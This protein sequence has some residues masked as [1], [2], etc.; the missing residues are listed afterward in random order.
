MTTLPTQIVQVPPDLP[1]LSYGDEGEFVLVLEQML[2]R[3]GYFS[4]SPDEKFLRLT[5]DAVRLF[6]MA[7]LGPDGEWLK[8][9]SVVG[10]K[11]WWALHNP[12]GPAQRSWIEA[13]VPGGLPDYRQNLLELVCSEHQRGVREIPDG[14]NWGD[15]VTKYLDG[16]G[17]A[18]W[19]NYFVSWAFKEITG[20]YLY[21]YRQGHVLS[22]WQM[23]REHKH[24][25]YKSRNYQPIPGDLFIMLYRNRGGDLTGSGHI[26][27]VLRTDSEKGVAAFNTVEGNCGNRVKQGIRQL[28]QYTLFGFINPW[29]DVGKFEFE[30]GLVSAQSVSGSTR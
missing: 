25:H 20:D 14:A 13:P 27:F 7:H 19:C 22:Q 29:N 21:G 26:G 8:P 6:Q 11:T 2:M 16:V 28:D 10:P 5:R 23:S 3:Q 17:P 4:G 15:G 12:T 1:Q 30:S 18:P 24:A 9:D